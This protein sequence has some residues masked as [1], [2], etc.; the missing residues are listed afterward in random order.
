MAEWPENLRELHHV[1]HSPLTSLSAA[2]QLLEVDDSES[3]QLL[4]VARRGAGR[5]RDAAATLLAGATELA[6]GAY[7]LT[8]PGVAIDP[9]ARGAR[10][11]IIDRESAD[12]AKT[13]SQLAQELGGRP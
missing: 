8:R 5:L 13:V 7:L 9:T 4:E 11:V 6:P 2:L 3:A 10:F 12:A 1:F